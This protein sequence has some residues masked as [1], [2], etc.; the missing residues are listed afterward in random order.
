MEVAQHLQIS[1]KTAIKSLWIHERYLIL[2]ESP[3]IHKKAESL[4][5]LIKWRKRKNIV[6]D[7]SFNIKLDYENYNP[8]VFNYIIG[9]VESDDE[10]KLAAYVEKSKWFKVVNESLELLEK[11]SYIPTN[12]DLDSAARPFLLWSHQKLNNMF[13][14]IQE[15]LFVDHKTI[16]NRLLESLGTELINLLSRSAVLELHIAKLEGKLSGD[17]P[18]DRYSSFIKYQFL[19]KEKLVDFYEE[20][21]VLTRLL[22]TRSIYFVDNIVEA[23]Y[24]FIQDFNEI[25]NMIDIKDSKVKEISP[26]RGD[27]HQKGHTVISFQFDNNNKVFYKPKN[28]FI[29]KTYN[30]F[31]QWINE[32]NELLDMST[33]KIIC[34]DSYT[35]EEAVLRRECKSVAEVERFYER[36]G[37][38]IG[39]TY[40]LR[41]GDFHYENVIA[42]GEYPSIIDLETIFQHVP[43]MEF[44]DSAYVES[45]KEYVNSVMWL[46]LLPNIHEKIG[47]DMS[48]LNGREQKANYK[49]LQPQNQKTDEM[50]YDYANF[51]ITNKENLPT[52]KGEPV[53]FHDYKKYIYKGF[54]NACM[55]F[56][57]HREELLSNQELL[58]SFKGKPVRS[59]LRA[60]SRYA[61]MLKEG[62]H[63]DY[64]RDGLDRERLLENLWSYAFPKKQVVSHEVKDML[65]GDIPIFFTTTEE[66]NVISSR[67][68]IIQDFYEKCSYDL[69]IERIQSLS[70]KEMEKQLS[71]IKASLGD[72]V[73]SNAKIQNHISSKI[74]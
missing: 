50:K 56:I 51:S 60:T 66:T 10:E 4:D 28:L 39:I 40:L 74:S 21:I 5:N 59:I 29:A 3:N 63:P 7:H 31:I 25:K 2:N 8:E 67:N 65:E 45:K 44:P 37:Q 53:S 15:N 35:W 54:N 62:T 57:R 36:F 32:Q 24:R 73:F 14:S 34:K 43:P 61:M 48:A 72:Y 69:V 38:L 64:L 70:K 47:M 30:H 26:G 71:Y 11:D 16:V 22:A 19:D 6:S 18:E 42:N 52:L 46:G 13:D 49:I 33:Y 20:Y 17:S 23:V 1:S 27:T 9:S 41:G 55:F 58:P 68:E 12:P